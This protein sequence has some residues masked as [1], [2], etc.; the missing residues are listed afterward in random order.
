MSRIVED[1]LTLAQ[2]DEPQVG[3][4]KPVAI[5]E[6]AL[7]AL[8]QGQV[9]AS[10]HQTVTLGRVDAALV[11]GD[12]DRL[13][14]MMRNLV[15]NAVKYTPSGGTITIDAYVLPDEQAWAAT[16]VAQE[17]RVITAPRP[18][19]FPVVMLSV[20]DTGI[21][22]ATEDLPHVFDRFYRVD[23]AR[24]RA[25][26]GTGLGLAIV[27]GIA[28]THGGVVV[29]HSEVGKGS[30]FAVLLPEIMPRGITEGEDAYD[31]TPQ[32]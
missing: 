5:D 28:E 25:S 3:E 12:P 8:R 31:D 23:K 4:R 26:G 11:Y 32:W 6:L 18:P 30:V 21:G 29:V 10:D 27:K 16:L 1:L 24:S 20:R 19:A 14:Q 9:L 15:E 2:L 22:I 7:Q 13:A 17:P